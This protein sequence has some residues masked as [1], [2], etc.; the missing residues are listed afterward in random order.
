MGMALERPEVVGVV[1]GVVE[2]VELVRREGRLAR[3]DPMV[4]GEGAL[5]GADFDRVGVASEDGCGCCLSVC[6]CMEGGRGGERERER[7][8]E[9]EKERERESGGRGVQESE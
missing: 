5:V 1:V 8:R 3:R 9:R 2:G 7:E 6:V 4:I